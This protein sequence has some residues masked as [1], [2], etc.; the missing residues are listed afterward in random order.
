MAKKR[1]VL[2]GMAKAGNSLANAPLLI[3]N[4]WARSMN[5]KYSA[6]T[7]TFRS[8]SI[9]HDLSEPKQLKRAQSKAK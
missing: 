5:E 4:N 2:L 6:I 3:N 7:S 1:D 9:L 8:E